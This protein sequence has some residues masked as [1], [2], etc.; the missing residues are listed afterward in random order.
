[1]ESK[2]SSYFTDP[3]EYHLRCARRS[4]IRSH[5]GT[6]RSDTIQKRSIRMS[7]MPARGLAGTEM[8]I[9]FYFV[10]GD[11]LSCFGMK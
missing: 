7:Y 3:L 4:V 1:M 8:L 10:P 5:M 6:E 2:A 9:N 11:G